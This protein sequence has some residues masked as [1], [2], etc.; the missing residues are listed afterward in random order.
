MMVVRT[1][2]STVVAACDALA[3]GRPWRAS[4]ALV[5]VLRDPQRRTPDVVLLAATAAA[6]WTGW[7]EVRDLLA[8]EP[9]VDTV[10]AGRGRVLLARAALETG[11]DSLARVHAEASIASARDPR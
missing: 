11:A 10:Q 3:Q 4:R 1:S 8:G 5:P 6:E 2:D 9:W 7:K